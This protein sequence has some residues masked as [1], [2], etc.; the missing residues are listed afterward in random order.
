MT[1]LYI[2]TK[3][4]RDL[5]SLKTAYALDGGI[6]VYAAK[7]VIAWPF[8]KV[9][10]PTG[11]AFRFVP[12]PPIVRDGIRYIRTVEVV[13]KGSGRFFEWAVIFDEGWQLALDDPRGARLILFNPFPWFR[14]I[15]RGQKVVQLVEREVRAPDWQES[16]LEELQKIPQ[17]DG[18][19]PRRKGS[20]G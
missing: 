2:K 11:I 6:D 9:E 18:R 3:L 19:G 20:S 10:V 14:F 15:R 16:T 8:S 12:E 5:P 17:P 7:T 13:K 4:G 1:I